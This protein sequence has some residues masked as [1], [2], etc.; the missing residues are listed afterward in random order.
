MN[1]QKRCH[2]A[3]HY[4]KTSAI[5]QLSDFLLENLPLYQQNLTF[6]CIGTDRSTGDSLGPL[7][8]SYLQSMHNFP[9]PVIGTLEKPLHALNLCDTIEQL[10]IDKP[11]VVAIDAC[12]GDEP[13]VG[14]IVANDDAIQPGKAVKKQLPPIGDFSIKGVVNIGGFMETT[15]LQTTRLHVTQSISNVISQAILLAWQRYLLNI[16]HNRNNNAYDDNRWQQIGH[17]YFR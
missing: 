6:C 7:V 5:W 11:F 17:T 8:G 1:Q 10:A 3:I 16:K 9:F 13:S 2:F 12:L 15:V 4:E 14:L